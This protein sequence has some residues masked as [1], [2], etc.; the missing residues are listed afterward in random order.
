MKTKTKWILFTCA[1]LVVAACVLTFRP[2]VNPNMENCSLSEGILNKVKCDPQTKDIYLLLEG[3]DKHFYINR[4][5]EHG[6]SEDTFTQL[7][8]KS[9]KLYSINHWTLLDPKSKSKHVAQVEQ[10]GKVLYTEF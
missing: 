1:I 5:L 7:I 2:I 8:G 10:N 4:G 6:L 9:I 3:Y